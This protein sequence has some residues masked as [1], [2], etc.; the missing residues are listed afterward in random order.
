MHLLTKLFTKK[1][2]PLSINKRKFRLSGAFKWWTIRPVPFLAAT[3]I[4]RIYLII[5]A[6]LLIS[7]CPIG[8]KI[9]VK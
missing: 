2:C 8:H 5:E 6:E 7:T 1:Q 3:N 4:C 9:V